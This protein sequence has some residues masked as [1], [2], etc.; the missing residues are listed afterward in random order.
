MSCAELSFQLSGVVVHGNEKGRELGFPTANVP[1]SDD[2]AIPSGVYVSR[3]SDAEGFAAWGVTN[4]G[5]HPTLGSNS[6]ILSET[7]LF[8][9]AVDLYGKNVTVE[10]FD[11][12]RDERKFESA[13]HLMLQIQKDIQTAKELLGIEKAPVK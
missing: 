3:L 1:L 12:L 6:S 9:D 5:V 2:L 10:L 7:Y 11:F 8:C 4:V 13:D